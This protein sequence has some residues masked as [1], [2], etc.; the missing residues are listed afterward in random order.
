MG[1]LKHGIIQPMDVSVTEV[2]N[3]GLFSGVPEE[4]I[5]GLLE[6]VGSVRRDVA[7]GTCVFKEGDQARTGYI[8]ISGRL[9]VAE[10]LGGGRKH[11]VRDLSPGNGVGVSLILSDSPEWGKVDGMALPYSDRLGPGMVPIWPG[12]A[13]AVEDSTLLAFD[14]LKMRQC[15]HDPSPRFHQIRLNA[16]RM[17]CEFLANIWLKL[18]VLDAHSI[19][20]RVML[21]LRRLDIGG[22]RTGI[23]RVPFDR[24]QFARYL[25]V[26]RSALSRTLSKL[27]STGRLDWRKHDFYLKPAI[28]LH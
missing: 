1:G 22:A 21:Y 20:D 12:S 8:V 15:L 11:I 10:D 23:V 13:M 9:V 24:E 27:R 7:R 25:G 5:P 2:L 28:E 16:M 17:L 4:E 19:E 14:L 26:N 18:T 3:A 6:A